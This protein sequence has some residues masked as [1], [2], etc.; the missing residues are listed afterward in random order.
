VSLGIKLLSNFKFIH[1]K[2]N[3]VIDFIDKLWNLAEGA[4]WG[5]KWVWF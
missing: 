4:I 5:P 2:L 3:T 1:K